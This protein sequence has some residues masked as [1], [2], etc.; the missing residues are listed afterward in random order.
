MTR[1]RVLDVG[2]FALMFV[3]LGPVLFLAL[4]LPIVAVAVLLGVVALFLLPARWLPSLAILLWSLSRV[5]EALQ[6]WP[7]EILIGEVVL[8]V[9]L[10]RQLPAILRRPLSLQWSTAVVFSLVGWL[11]FSTFL[12]ENPVGPMAHLAVL[13]AVLWALESGAECDRRV[14]AWTLVIVAA[15]ETVMTFDGFSERLYGAD[16]AQL[17]YVAVAASLLLPQVREGWIWWTAQ[18]GLVGVILMSQTRSV[19]F[20]FAVVSVLRLLPRVRQSHA[21]LVM[22]TGLTLGLL[23]VG[24]LTSVMGLNSA[25]SALRLASI[26]G[27]LEVAMA[28][29]LIGVGWADSDASNALFQAGFTTLSFGVYNLYLGILVAGGVVALL[30]F[31]AFMVPKVAQASRF[32]KPVMLVAIAFLAQGMSEMVLYPGSLILPVLFIALGVMEREP[33]RAVEE[34]SREDSQVA[35]TVDT[36]CNTQSMN[37]TPKWT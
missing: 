14:F 3:I 17:G 23:A 30:L 7:I 33:P 15:T 2:A 34:L 19:Y 24:P 4:R 12:A 35:R 21:Y 16:P 11:A 1:S 37:H 22:F 29:P 9:W 28:H 5:V 10:L 20:A 8:V 32:D 36:G 25:S 26:Q 13:A 6:A 18:A 31:A 27:G